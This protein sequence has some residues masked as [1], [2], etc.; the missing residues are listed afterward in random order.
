M[1]WFLT[2]FLFLLVSYSTACDR[3]VH[4]SNATHY[5]YDV[6]ASYGSTCGYGK[7]EFELSKGYFAAVLPSLYKQ[8]ASC[9]ACYK[10]RCKNKTLCNPMGS[11][12]VV[13]DIHY[14]NGTDFVLS[15]KAFFSMALMGKTQQLLNIDTIQVEYKRIPC[16][17]KNKNLLVEIV[18]WSHK[19]EVLAIKFLYQGGQTNILA[20]N[21]TQV[22]LE[23]SWR[24]MIRNFGAI[25]YIPNVVEG[26]LKLKMMVASGYN[27][28]KWI[29]T[30]YGIPADW[31]N[32]NIYDTGIQIKDHI[33]ENCPPNKC[34]DKPWK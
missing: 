31:K 2:L 28:N 30:K 7:L 22:G 33:L 1:G 34:G 20:V 19:P 15:K 14:N 21:I 24:G 3:C 6:P 13:T 8:G 11:K 17:Y 9:G 32:G 23:K 16:E 27:N 5:H 25:W 29:S 12:V 26:A 18:E 4:Q 10:V